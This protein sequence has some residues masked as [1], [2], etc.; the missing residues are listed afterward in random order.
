MLIQPFPYIVFAFLFVFV[1]RLL[2]QNLLSKQFM[3]ECPQTKPNGANYT[4]QDKRGGVSGRRSEFL[5]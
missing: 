1:V 4:A 3:A 2:S 5:V